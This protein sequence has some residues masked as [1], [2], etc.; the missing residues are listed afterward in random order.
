MDDDDA[1]EEEQELELELE[2]E[3]R[4]LLLYLLLSSSLPLRSAPVPS[5]PLQGGLGGG[6]GGIMYPS[7]GISEAFFFLA[8]PINSEGLTV[9]SFVLSPSMTL[10]IEEFSSASISLVC[11][12]HE[13]GA[14]GLAC[15]IS[16]VSAVIDF[17]VWLPSAT[18]Q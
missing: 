1:T 9:G 16:V 11:L 18:V 14:L 2:S 7:K 5:P 15:L 3:L 8:P 10:L 13:T 6:V 4:D 17:W 12:E